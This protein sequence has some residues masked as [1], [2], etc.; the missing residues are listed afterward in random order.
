MSK[1]ALI[2]DVAKCANCHNCVVAAKDEHD[3]N[4]FSGY[5][6]AQPR[7]G[8][9]LITLRREVRGNGP[10]VDAAYMPVMCNHCDEP[11]CVRAAGDG[12]VYKRPDGIV[13]MD[14][15]RTKGRK[16][17]VNSCPYHAIA[18]NE[19]REVPQTWIFDAHLLDQGWPRPR[20][21][22]VC[23]TDAIEAVKLED[24][25]LARRVETEGLRVLNPAFRTRPRVFY[26]NM[27]RFLAWFVGGNL[28]A[29]VNGRRENVA[30]ATVRLYRG[31]RLIGETVSDAFGD[32]KIDG[33]ES[34]EGD[35]RLDC[36][37]P[38]W[39]A[40]TTA[41]RLD[42]SRFIGPIELGR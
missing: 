4:D 37:H 27:E 2:I 28:V 30:G 25:A 5:A 1:W 7:D 41:A 29:D 42:A 36:S 26:R 10:M 40:A 17:V 3:G 12:S 35:Y 18:W 31:Q 6:A 33:L 32:F 15:E 22:Q 19:A 38:E 14:P 13:L 23:P 11:P 21:A 20:C 39:G 8:R 24:G 34:R 16:D 9:P